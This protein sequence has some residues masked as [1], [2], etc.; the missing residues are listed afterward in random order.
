[1]RACR[2]H[3][4]TQTCALQKQQQQK[5]LALHDDLVHNTAK[6]ADTLKSS[7]LSVAEKS[8]TQ[9]EL[10]WTQTWVFFL[11]N[12]LFTHSCN[13]AALN[14][15]NMSYVHGQSNRNV[16][17]QANLG[18]LNVSSHQTHSISKLV[19]TAEGFFFVLNSFKV[20]GSCRWATKI[21]LKK[22]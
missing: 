14:V 4:F 6:K 2:L 21:D 20:I 5:K 9:A 17:V 8:G 13:P 22:T 11:M 3:A 12:H 1:M 10:T 15:N 18:I 19:N 7:F 16:I